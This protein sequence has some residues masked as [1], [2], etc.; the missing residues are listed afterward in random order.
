MMLVYATTRAAQKGWGATETIALLTGS[1]V[2]LAAFVAIDSRTRAPLLPLRMFRRRTLA[3]SNLSGVFA[4][5][6][7]GGFFIGTLYTQLV[8]GYS[9]IFA[10]AAA[11]AAV[12]S[13]LLLQSRAAQPKVG[14]GAEPA[15]Q[16]ALETGT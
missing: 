13:A 16:P 6:A 4:G 11:L 15:L 5:V 3:R 14:P 1:V 12:L 9:P 7:L 10:A 8:L 2:L